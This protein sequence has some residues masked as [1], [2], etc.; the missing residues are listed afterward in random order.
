[1]C[2]LRLITGRAKKRRHCGRGLTIFECVAAAAVVA[3]AGLTVL[4]VLGGGRARFAYSQ[5]ALLEL[6]LG[7][8]LLDEVS[9]RSYFGS[10]TSRSTWGVSGYDGFVDGPNT[11]TDAAGSPYPAECQR[12]TRTVS[13]ST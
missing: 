6:R 10:G 13:V 8:H 7:E 4:S 11:L 3:L 2:V 1:M 5:R 9:S 12:I